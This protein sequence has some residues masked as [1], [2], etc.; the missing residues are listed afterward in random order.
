MA[1]VAVCAARNR[2]LK[3]IGKGRLVLTWYGQDVA[4]LVGAEDVRMLERIDR[5]GEM[6]ALRARYPDEV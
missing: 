5:A 6:E 4:G 3:L 1:R 2:L